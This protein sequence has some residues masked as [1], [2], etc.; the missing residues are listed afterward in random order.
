MLAFSGKGADNHC[1]P[2]GTSVLVQPSF[3][4]EV[5]DALPDATAILDREGSIVA[6]NRVWRMFAL[7]NGGR[8]EAT[9]VGVNY[10]NVCVRSAET[11]C[12]DAGEVFMGLQ[13][14]LSGATVESDREYACPSPAVGRWFNSRITPIGGSTGGAL[15]SHVNISRRVRSEQDLTHRASHDSLTGLGNRMQFADELQRALGTQRG[16]RRSKA[17]VG[18]LYIDLDGFKAVNDT[19]GHDAGDE[20]L[21]D[22][23]HRMRSQLRPQDCVA[24]LGGDEFAI[25][26]QRIE[27]QGLAQLALRLEAVLAKPHQIHG[28]EVVVGGSIGIHIAAAGESVGEAIRLADQAMYLVKASHHD[29]EIVTS[30]ADLGLR[31]GDGGH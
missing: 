24:R 12:A 30:P 20:V 7:D 1:V 15:V 10:L 14:V 11:G 8:P 26:A 9:G 2:S 5:L 23:A 17:D 13:A 4:T 27:S 25:C 22:A 16:R 6:V 28:R 19:F 3:A 29:P 21:L 18:I 31:N